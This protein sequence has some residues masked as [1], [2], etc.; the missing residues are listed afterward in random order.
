M[1][2]SVKRIEIAREGVRRPDLPG[3]HPGRHQGRVLR[4]RQ[5]R[6]RRDIKAVAEMLNPQRASDINQLRELF[7]AKFSEALKTVGKQFDF[8][9]LYIGPRQL[10]RQDHRRDRHRPE[11]LPARQ[12]PHR[13]PGADR[14][15]RCSTRD[16]ILDAE[17]IKKI[18][19]LTTQENSASENHFEVRRIQNDP[20]KAERRSAT[21]RCTSWSGSASR[22]KQKQQ[23]EIASKS[24]PASTPRLSQG[25]P[26]RAAAEVPKAARIAAEEEDQGQADENKERQI[27]VAHAE[28]GADRRRSRSSGWRKTA[29]WN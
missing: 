5:Q 15:W 11:R 4:S 14:S 24:L 3:Q 22:P 10:P 13:L 28:Q 18:T 21:R 29:C 16:N 7:E 19:E 26:G 20:Q 6:R 17:G 1:D 9:S 27:I 2:L 25:P 12:L 8:V 23:R